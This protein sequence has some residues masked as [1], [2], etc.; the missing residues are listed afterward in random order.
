MEEY[1]AI[2]ATTSTQMSVLG[3]TPTLLPIQT[4]DYCDSVASLTNDSVISKGPAT[5]IL[6]SRMEAVYRSRSGNMK[7]ITKETRRK[8]AGLMEEL[9][10]AT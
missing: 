5:I 10:L 3:I 2:I 8:R 4:E 6:V 7:K 1:A 9:L